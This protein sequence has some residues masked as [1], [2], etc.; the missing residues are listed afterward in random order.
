MSTPPLT[1]VQL[2]RGGGLGG[3]GISGTKGVEQRA[4]AGDPVGVLLSGN[5]GKGPD[6]TQRKEHQPGHNP[7]V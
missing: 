5:G 4:M 7:I 6:N 1:V 2:R 3:G